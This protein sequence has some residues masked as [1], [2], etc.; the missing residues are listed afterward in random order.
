L[1]KRDVAADSENL[2]VECLELAVV[3]HPGR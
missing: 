2:H 3:G 1:R